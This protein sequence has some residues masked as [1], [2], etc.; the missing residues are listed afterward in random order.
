MKRQIY[1]PFSLLENGQIPEKAI[2]LSKET[3]LGIQLGNEHKVLCT[4]I[5][6]IEIPE[7][8]ILG[9]RE[10]VRSG[11]IQTIEY[12]DEFCVFD[13]NTKLELTTPCGKV[14]KLK[15]RIKERHSLSYRERLYDKGDYSFLLT[16]I[17][18]NSDNNLAE[19]YFK[20]I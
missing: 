10:E 4:E 20:V 12:L 14:E 8:R 6:V 2:S 18:D 13:K 3:H 9:Y 7:R 15:P 11:F 1:V 17:I 16:T 19:G 5:Q